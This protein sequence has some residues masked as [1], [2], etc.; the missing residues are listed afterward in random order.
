MRILAAPGQSE[1]D[2]RVPPVPWNEPSKVEVSKLRIGFYVEDDY[3]QSSPA[4][5]RAVG[6]AAD[7]LRGS[8][9]D[10]VKWEAPP[11]REAVQL[12]YGLI[13]AGGNVV[14]RQLGRNPKTPQIA[15]LVQVLR[16]P[17][18]ARPTIARALRASGNERQAELLGYIRSIDAGDFHDLVL[19]TIRYRERVLKSMADAR[20]DAVICA[21]HP[22]PALRHGASY[23][24]GS[25]AG[26]TFL[27]N[28]MGVPAGSAAVT[29][30]RDDEQAGR[31][32]RT[33]DR[34]E[35]AAAQTDAGSV[36]LPIGVQVVAR[37][38]REDVVLAVMRRLQDSIRERPDYPSRPPL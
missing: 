8:V 27:W 38:W 9:A 11:T 4:V 30:V 13:S 32:Q 18:M 6:Q 24:L 15:G 37:P 12:F 36:G 10:V 14:I 33:R 25:V 2:H 28:L 35:R 19:R 29:R 1:I 16:T 7:A 3:F 17:V 34:V 20:L 21:V 31:E 26:C 22:L 5:K 23:L